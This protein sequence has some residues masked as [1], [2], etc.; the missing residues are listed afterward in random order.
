MR[1]LDSGYMV[2]HVEI[3]NAKGLAKVHQ[4]CFAHPWGVHDFV[5]FLQDKKYLTLGA[6]LPSKSQPVG[7]I[8]LRVVADEAEIISIAVRRKH[9]RKGLAEALLDAALDELENAAVHVLHLEVEANNKSAINL[10]NQAG[11]E[12]VGEREAYYRPAAGM[13]AANALMMKL[14]LNED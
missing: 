7:F 3:D 11:F 13:P 6:F 1:V 12:I 9:R 5:L 4:D 10:Y 14:F 2:R 8:L